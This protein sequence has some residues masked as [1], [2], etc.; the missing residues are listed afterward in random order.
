[1]NDVRRGGRE[2][3]RDAGAGDPR[4]SRS[5]AP[6]C[7]T[8]REPGDAGRVMRSVTELVMG[9]EVRQQ[10]HFAQCVMGSSGHVTGS[11]QT[12]PEVTQCVMHVWVPVLFR[13]A[14]DGCRSSPL[15]MSLRF[16]TALRIEAM[17]GAGE[18]AI[19][20]VVTVKDSRHCRGSFEV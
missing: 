1:M 13:W 8:Q 2:G 4:L 5:P 20:E 10:L 19:R 6:P 3:G 17:S 9:L 14:R 7:E 15:R 12:R 11:D 16:L 18:G